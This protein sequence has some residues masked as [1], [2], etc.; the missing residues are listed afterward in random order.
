MN[1][2]RIHVQYRD[3]SKP[4]GARV[5]LIFSGLFGGKTETAHTDRYGTAIVAHESVGKAE[6]YVN[7]RPVGAF[8]APGDTAVFVQ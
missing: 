7:G 4:K 3:G 8:R 2:S 1:Y 5:V 6:V